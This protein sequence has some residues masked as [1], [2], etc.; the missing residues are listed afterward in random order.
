MLLMPKALK[1][2]VEKLLRKL[3][4]MSKKGETSVPR[5]IPPPQMVGCATGTS[6]GIT[7]KYN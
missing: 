7:Q 4:Y 6:E 3:E 1:E 5:E 2:D